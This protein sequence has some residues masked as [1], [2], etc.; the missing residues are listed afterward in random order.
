M[1]H[2]VEWALQGACPVVSLNG[3]SGLPLKPSQILEAVERAAG[4]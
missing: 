1:A 4:R 2:E 3:V